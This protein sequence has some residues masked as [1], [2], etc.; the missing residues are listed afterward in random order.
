MISEG[1]PRKKTEGPKSQGARGVR[2]KEIEIEIEGEGE[3]ERDRDIYMDEK[4]RRLLTYG[5]DKRLGNK[6]RR[7]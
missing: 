6:T 4:T 5:R 3:G 1:N 2:E 7:I